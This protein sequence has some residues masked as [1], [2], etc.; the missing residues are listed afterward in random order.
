MRNATRLE[1][2][3]DEPLAGLVGAFV[4]YPYQGLGAVAPTNGIRVEAPVTAIVGTADTVVFGSYVI[5]T[6]RR[7]KTA[8]Q[9]IEV[10]PFEGATHAFDEIEAQDWRVRYDPALTERAHRMYAEFLSAAA[11][12][13]SR[14]R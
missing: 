6:L 7:M 5:K 2:L 10:T 12:R 8:G 14:I 9:P 1:G 13:S 4:I 11:Q 3:P